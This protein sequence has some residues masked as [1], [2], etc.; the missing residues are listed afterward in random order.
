MF[1]K[2]VVNEDDSI[3]AN[4]L[5][6]PDLRKRD[7]NEVWDQSV[8]VSHMS[9][10]KLTR[11]KQLL[12]L[13]HITDGTLNRFNV[14]AV[15]SLDGLIFPRYTMM[16]P[17]VRPNGLKISDEIM[18]SGKLATFRNTFHGMS[19][20]HLVRQADSEVV[21]TLNEADAMAIYQASSKLAI[22]LP[23]THAQPCGSNFFSLL[24]PFY[25]TSKIALSNFPKDSLQVNMTA[26]I[27]SPK[28]SNNLRRELVNG[29][30]R[31]GEVI[32]HKYVDTLPML[33][34][35][36][37]S[38]VF[39]YDRQ[40]VGL[41]QWKRFS[42]LNNYLKGFRLGELTLLTGPYGCGKK[43][44]LCEYA[45]DLCDQNVSTLWCGLEIPSAQTAAT[46]VEQ[47]ARYRNEE[48]SIDHLRVFYRVHNQTFVKMIEYHASAQDIQHVVI[49]NALLITEQGQKSVF[50]ELKRLA[51]AKHLHVTAVGHPRQVKRQL[52]ERILLIIPSLRNLKTGAYDADNILR[53]STHMTKRQSYE[54]EK[55]FQ[56]WKNRNAGELLL[57]YV[58][59][60]HFDPLSK[61]H[62]LVE[63][64]RKSKHAFND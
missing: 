64:K 36:V 12:Y 28:T 48:A 51:L 14:R 58:I 9:Q 6:R 32:A 40:N 31:H 7:M 4:A 61:C 18:P 50:A 19:G 23:E 20:Y 57:G 53:I 21:V 46:M 63:R 39:G 10:P 8:P 41:V 29:V 56:I 45:L 17:Q 44:F 62:S 35:A 16:G 34:D 2:A 13:R 43:T 52:L 26:T 60:M 27:V 1:R 24:S 37:R 33:R 15:S 22:V 5:E 30:I 42:L 38:Y 54:L 47:Y 55:Y 49:D 3:I 11:L 25:L 59:E